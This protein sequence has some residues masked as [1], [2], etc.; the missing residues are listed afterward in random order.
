M[1]IEKGGDDVTTEGTNEDSGV[2]LTGLR[3][4]SIGV[5]IVEDSMLVREMVHGMLAELGYKVVG[6]AADGVEAIDKA[7][8]LRPDVILMD[9]EMP[10]MD[11]LTATRRIAELS[12]PPVVILTAYENPRL[13]EKVSAAGAAAY[14]VKPPDR[15]DLHR[16][17]T[18]AIARQAD[19]QR[20]QKLNGALQRRHQEREQLL[21]WLQEAV[22]EIRTLRGLIPICAGC[23]K[24]RED[25]GYWKKI[26]VYVSEHS[27]AE[28]SHGMCPEC[29]AQYGW[30]STD[31]ES[32][33]Q[34]VSA[35]GG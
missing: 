13:I 26:E 23:K 33:S 35:G 14:L 16:A 29:A 34:P 9:L 3:P 24:V 21:R 11:G 5:L 1:G 2:L 32:E 7:R 27:S 20:L 31:D 28:F 25:D 19:I 17:I 6:R 12:G 4:G 10:R 8:E 30:E 15:G 18:V 22:A